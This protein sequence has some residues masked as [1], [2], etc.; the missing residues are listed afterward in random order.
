MAELVTLTVP[1]PQLT[2]YR[3]NELHLNWDAQSIQ[4]G[5]KGTN[6]EAK[7]VGYG[8]TTA[9]ALM[10][11]LNTKNFT[12]TS[13]HKEIMKRLQNDGLLGAGTI[14]GSPDT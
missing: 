4:I 11:V 1:P 7:H 10:N 3:V 5:L 9:T 6:G 2:T 8:S 12:S 14:S 13:M